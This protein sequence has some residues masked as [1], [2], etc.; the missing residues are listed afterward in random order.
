MANPVGSNRSMY[1]FEGMC[2]V[3]DLVWEMATQ[4]ANATFLD[5]TNSQWEIVLARPNSSFAGQT[6]VSGY[7]ANYW[8]STQSVVLKLTPDIA[9]AGQA[10]QP[11]YLELSAPVVSGTVTP[12]QDNP[13]VPSFSTLTTDGRY[14]QMSYGTGFTTYATTTPSGTLPHSDWLIGEWA[15]PA[16]SPL[17]RFYF[18]GNN[19]FGTSANTAIS[20]IVSFVRNGQN[21]VKYHVSMTNNKIAIVLQGDPTLDPSTSFYS[22]G[23]FGTFISLDS[24]DT[25]TNVMQT[26]GAFLD[27]EKTGFINTDVEALVQPYVGTSGLYVSDGM[28]EASV[29]SSYSGLYYHA[30]YPAFMAFSEAVVDAENANATPVSTTFQPSKYTGKYHFSNI[31][32]VEPYEGYR[33]Y[34]EDV[35]AIPPWSVKRG[36]LFVDDCG[37]DINGNPVTKTYK[38]FGINVPNSMFN[39]SSPDGLINIGLRIS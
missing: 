33:G 29:L 15:N 25:Q 4:I 6:T 1:Y 26:C 20:N 9:V 11:V 3:D 18:A 17:S 31:Y 22:F 19:P 35:V 38:Y 7:C 13:L 10:F 23:H 28:L 39:Q 21:K 24:A 30:Y 2:T 12:S 5:G 8:G 16:S 14:I 27:A 34:L 32:L 36:D 37:K